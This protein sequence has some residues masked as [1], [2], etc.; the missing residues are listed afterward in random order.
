MADQV[1]AMDVRMAVAFFSQTD[2]GIS[3]SRFCAEQGISRQTFY[4]LKRRF[5]T[6]GLEGLVPRSRRPLRSPAATGPDAVAM[7]L[8][9]RAWLIDQGLDHGARSVRGWLVGQEHR[10]AVPAPSA[11]T[12]HRIFVAHGL[13]EPQPRKRPRSSFRRFQMSRANECWQMDGKDRRLVDGTAVKVLRIQDDCSRQIQASRAAWSENL[14]DAWTCVEIAVHRH[15]APAMFLTDN[16][17][18]FSQRRTRGTLNEFEARLRLLG[19]LPVTSS[20][21]HPQTCGKKEREWQTLDRWLDA[22]PTASSLEELQSQ[23]DAYD[24]VFNHQRPHQALDGKTPAQRYREADKATAAPHPL[25]AP[26]Q[27]TQVLVRG[28]GTIDLG[29]RQ[30]MSIGTKWAHATVTVMREDPAIAVFHQD[31]L[32][33]FIHLDPDRT[34]QRRTRR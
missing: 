31:Q 6:E 15:G 5:D 18:S 11:R 3:V 14:T 34:Y 17:A 9:Q 13:I 10:P 30:Q 25:A 7:V 12:I 32:I 23:L 33:E 27:L 24:L 19:I 1:V 21:K 20:L 29:R 2:P 16:G 4:V 8:A 28:N 26:T 22:R